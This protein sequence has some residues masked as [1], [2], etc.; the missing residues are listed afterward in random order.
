MIGVTVLV[1]IVSDNCR[2]QPKGANTMQLILPANA[3]L[4]AQKCVAINDVRYYLGGIH[5]TKVAIEATNGHYMYQ[6]KLK[7][8]KYPDEILE[9]YSPDELPESLIIK[10][11]QPIK[12]PAVKAGC[13]FIVFDIDGEKV[14]A[15]TIDHLGSP[16]GVY[17]GEVVDYRFPDTERLIPSGKSEPHDFVGFNSLYLKKVHDIADG[18]FKSVKMTAYGEDKPVKFEVISNSQ[19]YDSMLV[20]MPIRL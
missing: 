6:A 5:V 9:S 17:L 1:V 13:E 19:Y 14:I 4:N 15:T 12:K 11:V 10:M 3:V 8:F 20:V 7:D 18:R 2:T 16:L